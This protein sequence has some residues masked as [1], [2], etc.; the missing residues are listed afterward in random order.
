MSML[1]VYRKN[2]QKVMAKDMRVSLKG[3]EQALT[4]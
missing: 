1:M 4:I 2:G 3:E